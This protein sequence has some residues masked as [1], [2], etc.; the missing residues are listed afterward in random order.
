MSKR[1]KFIQLRIGHNKE[2]N[3]KYTKEVKNSNSMLDK[4]NYEYE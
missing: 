3:E 4:E 2:N 1:K